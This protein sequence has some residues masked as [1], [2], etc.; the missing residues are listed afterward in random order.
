[1]ELH[2]GFCIVDNTE[3]RRARALEFSIVNNRQVDA[4]VGLLKEP[5]TCSIQFLEWHVDLCIVDNRE[6]QRARARARRRRSSVLSTIHKSICQS[7]NWIENVCGSLRR[8]TD[9]STCPLWTI[10]NSNARARVGVLNCPQY[11]SRRAILKT[12]LKISV[13]L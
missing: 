5:Q 11:I 8:P 3:R 13:A 1:M 4:S 9:A 2:A 10:E 12:E 7:K 6:L